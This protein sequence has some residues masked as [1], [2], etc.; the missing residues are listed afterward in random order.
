MKSKHEK[1]LLALNQDFD[2]IVDAVAKDS[3]EVKLPLAPGNYMNNT[4]S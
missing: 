1:R 3:H 4:N 2:G